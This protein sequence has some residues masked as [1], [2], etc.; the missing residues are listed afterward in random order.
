M[1]R[2]DLAINVL[3]IPYCNLTL[4]SS[5]WLIGSNCSARRLVDSNVSKFRRFLILYSTILYAAKYS[6]VK[7]YLVK[8]LM[9]GEI[10]YFYRI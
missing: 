9:N 4:K 2:C 8:V 6:H 3:C 1:L 7:I 5:V 10:L